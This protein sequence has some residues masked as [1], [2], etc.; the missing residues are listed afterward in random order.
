MMI[1]RL[2]IDDTD[3]PVIRE[4][5]IE[6]FDGREKQPWPPQIVLWPDWPQIW[7]AL[8]AEEGLEFELQ[9][10]VEAVTELIERIAGSDPAG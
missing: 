10:A 5:C 4:A 7:A 9:E 3:L 8:M 2:A 6:I 1:E